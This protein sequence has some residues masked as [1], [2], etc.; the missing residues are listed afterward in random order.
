MRESLELWIAWRH[1]RSREGRRWL[2][3]V[4]LVGGY[5]ALVGVGFLIWAS[6][7]GDIPA[8]EGLEF[9]DAFIPPAADVA[10]ILGLVT[11][12]AGLLVLVFAV[13]AAV[14][15]LLSAII[16]L[17]VAQGCMAL[18]VVLSLMTG[19][20]ID[21]REKIVEQRAEIRIA[22]VDGEAFDGFEALASAARALPE[23]AGAS[24]IAEGEV[25]LRS[26]YNRQGALL[27]GVEPEHHRRV[28]ALAKM[29]QGGDYEYLADPSAGPWE[30]FDRLQEARARVEQGP[31][32]E[33]TPLADGDGG[34]TRASAS[35]GDDADAWEDDAAATD[36]GAGERPGDID[37]FAAA[38][39]DDAA[40]EDPSLEIAKL[41]ATGTLPPGDDRPA[42]AVDV[43][44]GFV[45]DEADPSWEDP[46]LEIPRLREA[47]VLPEN[48]EQ[49]P[50]ATDDSREHS[51]DDAPL[52][53]PP[54]AEEA[55][56]YA[57]ILLGMD[58]ADE[59]GIPV[60]GRLQIITPI[61]RMTPAGQVPSV[62]PVRAV[63][64][65]SS[66]MY[67]YDHRNVY[68]PLDRVQALLRLGPR[69]HALDVKLVDG[70]RLEEGVAALRQV[71]T[72]L[73]RPDLEVQSWK[74]LHRNLFS[75]MFLEKVAM[76]IGLLFVVL[77]AAFGILATNLIS[78]L[79]KAQEIAILKAM[80]ASDRRISRLFMI[81][82]LVVGLVGSVLGIGAGLLFCAL[83]ARHG[84]PLSA[85]GLGVQRLPVV[86]SLGEVLAVGV[87]ALAIVWLSSVHPA[88]T[89]ARLR[90]TQ[91]LR[92]TE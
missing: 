33:P 43:S 31:Q 91:G 24:A 81:E 6:V 56:A 48:P 46:A 39:A 37:A 20:E 2:A 88:R 86:V 32:I 67:A 75:A 78:V 60:G 11:L 89:A 74:V 49:P 16:T 83:L 26:P 18:V 1:L 45:D 63:G 41:R 79:D 10:R 44:H 70:E 22:R 54:A 61:G 23:V 77:V 76:F 57:P 68:A 92:S 38:D 62:L 12:G 34:S 28:T 35:E 21:L 47:G 36:D 27:V 40:W 3:P 59:L 64:T 30:A 9:A 14:F 51:Q 58:L 19:L 71:V 42:A 8:Y 90:P 53:S 69:V 25:M 50:P 66:G 80:G 73:G 5:V 29:V 13:L 72:G 65:F 7:R 4:A 15:N 87:A 52:E 17:S 85:E 55:A 84:L 82:G